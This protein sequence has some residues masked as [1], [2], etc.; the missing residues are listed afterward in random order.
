VRIAVACI[1]LLTLAATSAPT[2]VFFNARLEPP[3]GRVLSGWGQFSGAWAL[4]Q[5]AAKND[6]GALEA[7]SKAVA[8]HA[9]AMISFYVAPDFSIVSGFLNHYREFAAGHGFFIGQVAINF[10]GAEHDVAIGMRDPD[11]MVLADGL[12][13]VGRP[14]LLG[15]GS[16]FNN[17]SARYEPSAYIGAFRHATDV[18]RNDHL[19]FA[20]VWCATARGFPD[21]PYMKWYPGDDVV[22]W[23]GIDLLDAN[24]LNGVAPF[25]EDAARH[26]KPVLIS[27]AAGGAK[28]EAE[29]L[30]WYASLFEFIRAHPAIK[31]FSLNADGRFARWPKVSAYLKQQLADPRFIAANESSAVLRP[32]HAER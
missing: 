31:A 17:P 11:W 10:P 2:P 1:A 29:A 28:S 32:P 9:P 27:A 19:N 25:V 8:P 20:G 3:S 18:M 16:A 15:I 26:R 6:A 13:D 14:V 12:R 22:D 5:P 7:Y 21:S 30:K 4:G 23:W 24:D